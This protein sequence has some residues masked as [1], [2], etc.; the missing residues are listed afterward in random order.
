MKRFAR[1]ALA[2]LALVRRAAGRELF[3]IVGAQTVAAIGSV[4]LLLS[5]RELLAEVE[6]GT[7]VGDAW[8]SITGVV[9]ALVVAGTAAVVESARIPVVATLVEREAIRRVVRHA[10]SVPFERFL[11]ATFM[12]DVRRS[13]DAATG[14]TWQMTSGLF[15]LVR[16]LLGL[17]AMTVVLATTFPAALA[18]LA[19]GFV[20]LAVSGRRLSRRSYETLVELTHS[21]RESFDLL[22]IL[23]GRAGAAEARAYGTV[24]TLEGRRDELLARRVS[25]YRALGRRRVQGQVIALALLAVMV[26]VVIAFIIDAAADG[27]LAIGDALIVVGTV[28]ALANGA[29]SL[30]GSVSSL[31]ETSLFLEDQERFL[32]TTS[33][34]GGEPRTE[35]ATLS[36]PV[37][38]S[39]RSLT[40]GYPGTGRTALRDI[41]VGVAA[42]EM[43]AVVGANGSGKSTLVKVL[44]G[45]IVPQ[46]GTVEIAG[47]PLAAMDATRRRTLVA[48]AFHD[49]VRYPMTAST[50]VALGWPERLDDRNGVEQATQLAGAAEL[51]ASLPAGGGTILTPEYEGGVDLSAGQWQRIALARVLFASTPVII[52]DEPTASM[53]VVA[54]RNVLMRLRTMT[55]ARTVV[56]VSHR[57]HAAQLAD[58]V[59]VMAD[60]VVVAEG[61][62]E[63]LVR[64]PGWYQDFARST[65][66]PGA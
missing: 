16:A 7:R 66:L 52:L 22:M 32:A 5:G 14:R 8:L 60:G 19:V 46:R 10:T 39:G 42:G 24:G 48:T 17:A 44:S 6:Q 13:V 33:T 4:A 49:A 1:T 65:V 54:E 57:L 34:A 2:S 15:A 50:N 26:S 47:E 12:D 41:D 25:Y 40:Y 43:V 53:D 51:L 23:T 11:D 29:R 38:V 31:L 61:T 64:R 63:E 35:V 58:R 30:N 37:A 45:L 36:S 3:V 20:P 18:A 55:P 59:I 21:E 62:H 56:V 27:A 28:A 9:V